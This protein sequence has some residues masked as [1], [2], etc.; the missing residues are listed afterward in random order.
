MASKITYCHWLWISYLQLHILILGWLF[1]L[2]ALGISNI[3]CLKVTFLQ[4][5]YISNCTFN[6]MIFYIRN[7]GSP[8]KFPSSSTSYLT[9]QLYCKHLFVSGVDRN[10]IKI[11]RDCNCKMFL[12]PPWAWLLLT[13]FENASLC[14]SHKEWVDG[15]AEAFRQYIYSQM[16]VAAPYSLCQP[17][18]DFDALT[19]RYWLLLYCFDYTSTCS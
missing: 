17:C 7:Q 2:G 14:S 15:K 1:Y 12:L 6:H 9:H 5:A 8:T 18:S 4:I 11:R 16:T 13:M 3:V 19:A 10:T